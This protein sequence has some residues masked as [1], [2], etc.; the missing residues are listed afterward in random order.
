MSI[1]VT[2]CFLRKQTGK[3]F[4]WS[5]S[6]PTPGF[7]HSTPSSKGNVRALLGLLFA[8]LPTL[9]AG[10]ILR[11]GSLICF[12]CVGWTG[13][14]WP[15]GDTLGRC[16]I[17]PTA[18]EPS[19]GDCSWTFT[20]G[21]NDS[22][23]GGGAGAVDVCCCCRWVSWLSTGD[24]SGWDLKSGRHEEEKRVTEK[25]QPLQALAACSTAGCKTG[26]TQL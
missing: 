16:S 6:E 9:D 11:L 13:A 21:A 22:N 8:G 12:C 1:S 2:N 4:P 14:P 17:L 26:I 19:T 3:H 15:S 20:C 5:W 23:P 24:G 18:V 25:H 10:G 7:P